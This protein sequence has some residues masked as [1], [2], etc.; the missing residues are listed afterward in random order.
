MFHSF[1]Y[2]LFDYN[3]IKGTKFL[4]LVPNTFAQFS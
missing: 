4:D 1:A 3:L 2:Y